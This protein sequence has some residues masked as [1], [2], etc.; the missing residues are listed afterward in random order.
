MSRKE[1]IQKVLSGVGVIINDPDRSEDLYALR[2][3][4]GKTFSTAGI[5]EKIAFFKVLPEH[6]HTEYD[7]WF[8]CVTIA[9]YQG[10][11]N[12]VNEKQSFESL[13]KELLK[14]YATAETR[15]NMM[16]ASD[17]DEMF[18][19]AFCNFI[20]MMELKGSGRLDVAKL[21]ADLLAWGYNDSAV[22][23]RWARTVY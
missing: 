1:D 10:T 4:F 21:L 20:I 15:F 6:I 19:N 3:A 18:W 23:Q 14:K 9:A 8:V 12:N 17:K 2:R 11:K 16:L 5:R 7:T 22:A 13:I